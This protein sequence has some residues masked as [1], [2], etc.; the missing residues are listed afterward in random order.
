MT[1]LQEFHRGLRMLRV[2]FKIICHDIFDKNYHKGIGYYMVSGI[3][4]IT[5]SIYVLTIFLD[6]DYYG[7]QLS[8]TFVAMWTGTSQVFRW[9]IE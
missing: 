8:F 6:Y 5:V 4:L 9:F 7:V 3:W 2:L 1:P